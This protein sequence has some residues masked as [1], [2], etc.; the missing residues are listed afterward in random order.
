MK[1]FIVS[2]NTYDSGPGWPTLEIKLNKEV[3]SIVWPKN[4]TGNVQ[5]FCK[6]GSLYAANNVIIT[7]SLGVL[8][9]R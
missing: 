9:E 3:T 6:D 7:V 4:S 2:Q 5:V 8:Q 1:I